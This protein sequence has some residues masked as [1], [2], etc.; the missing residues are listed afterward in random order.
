MD[1]EIKLENHKDSTLYVLR[2]CM[3]VWSIIPQFDKLTV[4]ID[5]FTV[6]QT[7]GVVWFFRQFL[8]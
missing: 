3:Y 6:R 2:I 1:L 8:H 7:G 4:V 5:R